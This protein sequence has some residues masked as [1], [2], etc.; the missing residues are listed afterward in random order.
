ML[1]DY[2]RSFVGLVEVLAVV[3]AVIGQASSPGLLSSHLAAALTQAQIPRHLLG[4]P[5]RLR[6]SR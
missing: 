1:V 4:R 3:G 2:R 6:R 5:P